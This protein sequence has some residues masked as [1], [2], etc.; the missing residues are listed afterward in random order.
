MSIFESRCEVHTLES[1]L[2]KTHTS[3]LGT[4]ATGRCKNGVTNFDL[5]VCPN[6]TTPARLNCDGGEFQ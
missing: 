4:F 6:A 1:N 3:V 2:K 5:P